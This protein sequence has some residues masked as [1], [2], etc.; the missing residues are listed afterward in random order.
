MAPPKRYEELTPE[1]AASQLQQL[2]ARIV[3][4]IEAQ[5][6][7]S[8]RSLVAAVCSGAVCGA[9]LLGSRLRPSPTLPFLVVVCL[10]V[11]CVVI[12]ICALVGMVLT[13]RKGV[14]EHR[15][16]RVL[17]VLRSSAAQRHQNDE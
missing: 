6:R 10:G 17:K 12:I 3:E 4:L 8:V 15:R 13:T 16:V 5:F 7:W 1:E 2:D 14:V 9:L 11:G